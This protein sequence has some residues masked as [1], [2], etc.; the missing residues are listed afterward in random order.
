MQQTT[1][2]AA[3]TVIITTIIATADATATMT[4]AP[5]ANL[6][7]KWDALRP[8]LFVNCQTSLTADSLPYDKP[9]HESLQA[10]SA[11]HFPHSQRLTNRTHGQSLL[12]SHGNSSN[13][14]HLVHG[15]PRVYRFTVHADASFVP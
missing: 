8:I 12:R 13:K 4:D 15:Y 7:V 9:E 14:F 2:C 3:A 10:T 11:F 6:S 1:V 5:A